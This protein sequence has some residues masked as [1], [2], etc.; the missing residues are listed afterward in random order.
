[1]CA[2]A[3]RVMFLFLL[4]CIQ[5]CSACVSYSD[6]IWTQCVCRIKLYGKVINIGFFFCNN[7]WGGVGIWKKDGVFV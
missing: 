6:V 4:I 7:R 1:M 5:R 3:I 2:A